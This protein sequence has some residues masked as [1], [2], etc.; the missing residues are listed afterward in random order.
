MSIDER[1]TKENVLPDTCCAN[2]IY[3]ERGTDYTYYCAQSADQKVCPD[4]GIPSWC[5]GKTMVVFQPQ[6][7]LDPQPVQWS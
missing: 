4:I 5:P 7:V 3:G 6:F 1:Y 2:C